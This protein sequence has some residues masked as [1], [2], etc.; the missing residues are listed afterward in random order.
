M[1]ACAP[2]LDKLKVRDVCAMHSLL[3]SPTLDERTRI[4]RAHASL[5]VDADRHNPLHEDFRGIKGNIIF[6]TGKSWAC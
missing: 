2:Y 1:K 3:D 5:R 6:E 4:Y